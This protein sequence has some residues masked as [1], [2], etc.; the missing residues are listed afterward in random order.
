LRK[1]LF[2]W[3]ILPTTVKKIDA[4]WTGARMPR[5]NMNEVINFKIS[6][7]RIETQKQIV[8]QLDQLQTQTKKLETIL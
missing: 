7:P 1:L 6:I 8:A 3:F 5:A 2:Y 4:T